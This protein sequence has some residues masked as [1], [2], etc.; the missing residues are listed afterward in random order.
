MGRVEAVGTRQGEYPAGFGLHDHRHDLFGA[1]VRF[2]RFGDLFDPDLKADG[3]GQFQRVA[4]DRGE[5]PALFREALVV[6]DVTRRVGVAVLPRMQVFIELFFESF[7]TAVARIPFVFV[8]ARVTDQRRQQF[9]VGVYP[10]LPAFDDAQTVQDLAARRGGVFDE[11]AQPAELEREAFEVLGPFGGDVVAQD[12]AAAF[13]AEFAADLV[14][15]DT[16]V[17]GKKLDEQ[18]LFPGVDVAGVDSGLVE[19]ACRGDMKT[20]GTDDVAAF[21][22]GRTGG[23]QPGSVPFGEGALGKDAEKDGESDRKENEQGNDLFRFCGDGGVAGH[24][25]P[26]F[27]LRL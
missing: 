2:H 16:A 27:L 19:F 6:V 15:R 26:V 25:V 12:D 20:V 23:E 4:V 24:G 5:I 1:Q 22:L 9:A 13:F 10:G 11:N 18:L 3:N 17:D 21:G 8:L 14:C 7:D